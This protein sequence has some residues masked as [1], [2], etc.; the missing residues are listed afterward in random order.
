MFGRGRTHSYMVIPNRNANFIRLWSVSCFTNSYSRTNGRT[1]RTA[2]DSYR[3]S[4][5]LF[6]LRVKCPNATF[7]I[8]PYPKIPLHDILRAETK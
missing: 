6:S 2:I 8:P 7:S 3:F 1:F 5:R 4:G